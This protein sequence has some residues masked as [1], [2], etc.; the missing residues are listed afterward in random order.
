MKCSH[1]P[2]N[3]KKHD[4][5]LSW[6]DWEQLWNLQKLEFT[7]GQSM[8]ELSFIA[9]NMQICGVFFTV[10]WLLKLIV[11]NV[12]T[13]LWCNYFCWSPD[14]FQASSFQLLKLEN[15]LRWTFF[16]Y[17]YNHSTIIMNFIYISHH[18]TAQEDMNSTNWP[19]SQCV[20]YYSQLSWSSVA[21]V[22][23]RSRVQIP[24]KP[25]YFLGF[26]LP[27]IP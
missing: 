3:I 10:M 13:I 21:P 14:I 22:L 17:I 19:R 9:A 4:I 27:I 23:R 20:A 24:L 16:T 2:H 12:Y 7:H 8:Q 15:L 18:F 6:K 5:K 11:S 1:C 25:W 26:F